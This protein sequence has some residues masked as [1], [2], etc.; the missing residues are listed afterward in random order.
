MEIIIIIMIIAKAKIQSD[1]FQGDALSP[2]LFII[3][4][5]L[6]N[7]IFRK[8]TAAYKLNKSQEKINQTVCKK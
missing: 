3:A 5:M 8:S 4:M 6:R 7:Q 2:L 1:T